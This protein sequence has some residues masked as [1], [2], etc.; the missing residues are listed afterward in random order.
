MPLILGSL[1]SFINFLIYSVIMVR[2]IKN[3]EQVIK[4]D[5]EGYPD[6]EKQVRYRVVPFIW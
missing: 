6:Y 3:E 2:R 1:F 4:K 5:L